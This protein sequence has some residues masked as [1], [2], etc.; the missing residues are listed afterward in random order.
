MDKL[1]ENGIVAT[2]FLIGQNITEA[3]IPI[4][5]RQLELGCE[6][7]NHSLTHSDMTKFTAEEIINEIQ[8][9]N[10]KIYD[11]VGVTPAFF[12]PPY[13]SVNNTMYENIDLAFI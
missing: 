8:K 5:E 6:I 1:E 9:T 2:F 13:I 3:T 12:R 4:M 7:A 11:A 10:Q